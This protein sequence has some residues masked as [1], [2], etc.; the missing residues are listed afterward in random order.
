MNLD[1]DPETPHHAI[2][3]RVVFAEDYANYK[4]GA[5]GIV[6]YVSVSVINEPLYRIMMDTGVEKYAG[7]R[8]LRKEEP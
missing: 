6:T 4:A 1:A 7:G 3:D 2:G 5:A 8:A